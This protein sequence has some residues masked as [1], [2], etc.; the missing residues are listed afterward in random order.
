MDFK[1]I[2]NELRSYNAELIAVTKTQEKEAIMNL[3]DQGQ[4]KFAENKVQELSRKKAVL[5]IDVQWHMIGQ[6]QTNKV[7]QV[8]S[9]TNMIQSG[10]RPKVLAKIDQEAKSLHLTP[11]VL[12]QVHVAQEETKSG[13]EP[14]ELYQWLDHQFHQEAVNIRLAGIMGMASFTSDHQQVEREFLQIRAIFDKVKSE[15]FQHDPQ[16]RY[17]SMGMSGDYK[18]ALACGSNMVR[19]GSILFQ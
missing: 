13:F 3:Y 15:Y 12:L 5:P 10:D 14:I 4:R 17:C 1:Q 7:K 2:L 8:L 18:I 11:E 16:F 9:E 19:L 6:L